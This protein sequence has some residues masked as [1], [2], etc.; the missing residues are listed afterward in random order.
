MWLLARLAARQRVAHLWHRLV[1]VTTSAHIWHTPL[2]VAT[3]CVNSSLLRLVCVLLIFASINTNCAVRL[4]TWT[5]P[6]HKEGQGLGKTGRG[7]TEPV[8]PQQLQRREGL[9]FNTAQDTIHIIGAPFF[10]QDDGTKV[11]PCPDLAEEGGAMAEDWR[12]TCGAPLCTVSMTKFGLAVTMTELMTQR[13]AI[14]ASP[15]KQQQ[16]QS[17]LLA[18]ASHAVL[19]AHAVAPV[20][21][22]P[23]H[24]VSDALKLAHL[25]ALF[26]VCG[27]ADAT[28]GKVHCALFGRV[29]LGFAEYLAL[30]HG[31]AACLTCCIEA[32]AVG[33]AKDAAAWSH[34]AT[35]AAVHALE[36]TTSQNH[37]AGINTVLPDHP[38]H[39]RRTFALCDVG[40][41]SLEQMAAGH[42]LSTELGE[43]TSICIQKHTLLVQVRA[44]LCSLTIGTPGV[45]GGDLVLRIGDCYTR[46]TASIL[47][48]LARSFNQ[49][50]IIKPHTSS[51]LDAEKFVICSGYVGCT[52]AAFTAIDRAIDACAR[53]HVVMA[54][55]P[56]TCLL[57]PAF[58]RWLNANND[59]LGRRQLAAI[60]FAAAVTGTPSAGDEGF[61]ALGKDAIQRLNLP[62]RVPREAKAE[63]SKPLPAA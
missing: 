49:T 10:E 52:R 42:T 46:F 55:V 34:L 19:A 11:H 36:F 17:P 27:H 6:R 4:Y 44:A 61:V 2:P 45:R 29:T 56:M 53:G 60:K 54:F 40:S 30:R 63:D 39:R 51:P 16:A 31:Q 7:I 32:T 57:Q 21:P 38:D 15:A 23:E 18:F 9:G 47:F 8:Q 1:S 13:R 48:L 41:W 25:D 26:D 59:R 62:A 50:R 24:I 3:S 5:N 20:F 35:Q 28:D 14:F 22:G 33:H 37:I 43:G 58:M 12:V